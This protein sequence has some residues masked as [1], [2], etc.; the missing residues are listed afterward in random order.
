MCTKSP[1]AAAACQGETDLNLTQGGAVSFKGGGL[2]F[3]LELGE[4]SAL[5][6]VGSHWAMLP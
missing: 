3:S 5:A 6:L 2:D 4:G 1:L